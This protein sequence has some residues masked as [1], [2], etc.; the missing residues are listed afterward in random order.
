VALLRRAFNAAMKDVALIED[1]E[2][3]QIDIELMDGETNA[4]MIAQL[5]ATPKS[6][7]AKLQAALAH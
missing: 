2:K 4:K 3:L 6:V 7:V 1:A 5:Y